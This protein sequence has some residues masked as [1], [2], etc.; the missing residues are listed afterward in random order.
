MKLSDLECCPF[1]KGETYY[2]KQYAK[3]PVSYYY[4]FDGSEADNSEMHIDITYDYTG[5]VYCA[6]CDKVLGNIIT[7]KLSKQA[8]KKLKELKE[9]G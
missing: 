2:E 7:D 8:E 3:G 4:N 6:D 5:R 9:N 1:C